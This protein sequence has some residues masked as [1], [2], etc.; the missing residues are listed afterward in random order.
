[1]MQFLSLEKELKINDKSL[2]YFY[3]HDNIFPISKTIF[4][5]LNNI[6]IN[7]NIDILCIDVSH[8]GNLIKR[9]EIETTPTFIFYKNGVETDRLTHIPTPDEIKQAAG[10]D[11][12]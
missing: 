9:F 6:E 8:F 10:R 12:L 4:S 1:M 5:L 11:I 3:S 2:L 7:L